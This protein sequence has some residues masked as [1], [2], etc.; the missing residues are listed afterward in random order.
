MGPLGGEFPELKA[1]DRR[2]HLDEKVCEVLMLRVSSFRVTFVRSSGNN[3][4]LKPYRIPIH[5]ILFFST[6]PR[7]SLGFG[8]SAL[9]LER[10]PVSLSLIR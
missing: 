8:V 3:E 5:C 7:V 2:A 10:K 9:P 6:N 4:N 1:V